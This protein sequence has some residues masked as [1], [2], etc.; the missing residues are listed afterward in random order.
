[1]KSLEFYRER[2]EDALR[3]GLNDHQDKKD[4]QE[5]LSGLKQPAKY[6][7]VVALLGIIKRLA[8]DM[9]TKKVLAILPQDDPSR[10][11]FNPKKLE[12]KG[13]LGRGGEHKVYM[14]EST[15][16]RIPSYALKLNSQSRGDL[17]EIQKRA[18]VFRKE[19]LDIKQRYAAIPGIVPD[20]HTLI[21]HD[22]RKGRP[23]MATVQKFYGGRIRDFF[24][25]ISREEL[26]ELLRN[27]PGFREDFI[28]FQQIAEKEYHDNATSIDFPG[29]KNF[30]VID[31]ADGPKLVIL[32]PHNS[33]LE[34]SEP[35]RVTKQ[36]KYMVEL[37]NI[38][39]AISH[40]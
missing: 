38:S 13:N 17:G 4:W 1:M 16:S 6:P 19:Y 11:P 8:P 34:T 21:T 37:R 28:K 7:K 36:A 18:S 30:S 27:N 22:L 26:M 39:E 2:V 29:D 20:E 33:V 10:L 32:D 35:D 31:A 9:V 25:D 3:E 5:L 15:D 12:F 23:I 24:N 14:L 40:Q